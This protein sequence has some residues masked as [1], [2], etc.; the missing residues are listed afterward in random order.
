MTAL[1]LASCLEEVIF[2]TTACVGTYP[3]N[4]KERWKLEQPESGL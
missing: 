1:A 2:S 4:W 3:R